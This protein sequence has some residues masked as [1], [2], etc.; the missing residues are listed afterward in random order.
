MC[1][2]RVRLVMSDGREELLDE[3]TSL[4]FDG[5][6]ITLTP[7]FEP[8]RELRG[9]EIKTVDCMHSLVHLAQRAI[10]HQAGEQQ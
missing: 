6:S 8:P 9:F 2:L 3:V 4:T 1:Q 5:D 10:D 7:L